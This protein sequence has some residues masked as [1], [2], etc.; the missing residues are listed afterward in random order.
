M[1]TGPSRPCKPSAVWSSGR[2]RQSR[3]SA[4]PPDAIRFVD[5]G[6][7][8]ENSRGIGGISAARFFSRPCVELN[9]RDF[10]SLRVD[11]ERE[12]PG[13][14]PG[15]LGGHLRPADPGGQVVLPDPGG[16]ESPARDHR[17]AAPANGIPGSAKEIAPHVYAYTDWPKLSSQ[18]DGGWSGGYRRRERTVDLGK[19]RALRWVLE[20]SQ[21]APVVAAGALGKGGTRVCGWPEGQNG[22]AGAALAAVQHPLLEGL[23][24]V[25]QLLRRVVET[26]PLR[27]L[28]A[29]L[30][31]D[32]HPV[33]H[34]QRV[35]P[36]E[37]VQLLDHEVWL[38]ER[39]NP[40]ADPA[41]RPGRCEPEPVG[42]DQRCPAVAGD[43]VEPVPAAVDERRQRQGP[44]DD[45][46]LIRFDADGLDRMAEA[47][48]RGTVQHD[49]RLPGQPDAERHRVH[50]RP[51][52]PVAG[53]ERVE[54]G[55]ERSGGPR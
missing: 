24:Q 30:V 23:E 22:A 16:A 28:V 2:G 31:D 15:R 37:P 11:F 26:G 39:G 13:G 42:L 6:S 12:D 21:T 55:G 7:S 41:R 47:A 34:I 44:L 9:M 5:K 52:A 51:P 8:R 4:P 27:H 36:R 1:G 17:P 3:N 33:E 49:L 19:I 32:V 25:T 10:N 43:D 50:G 46:R 53:R 20:S 45:F 29:A 18:L 38:V 40:D 35:A 54:V 14:P 48:G